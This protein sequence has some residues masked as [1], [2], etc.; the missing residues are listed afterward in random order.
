MPLP[1]CIRLLMPTTPDVAV[2]SLSIVRVNV[3][4]TISLALSPASSSV[5][6]TSM[7]LSPWLSPAV[8]MVSELLVMVWVD[9]RVR[10]PFP[11]SNTLVRSIV[12][13]PL[14]PVWVGGSAIGLSIVGDL[15]T[16]TVN[17]RVAKCRLLGVESVAV[18]VRSFAPPIKSAPVN[19]KSFP[20]WDTVTVVPPRLA[21]Y[22]AMVSPMASNRLT[23]AARV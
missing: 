1:S 17:M 2:T 7:A 4:V 6:V 15:S 22:P 16:L 5:A 21:V 13:L 12:T 11:P 14:L 18:K 19:T 10:V 23:P 8:S 3:L 9:E 20:D